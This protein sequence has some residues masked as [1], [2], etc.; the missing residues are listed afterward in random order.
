[1]KDMKSTVDVAKSLEA[2]AYSATANGT[3]VDLQGYEGALFVY[4]M[5]VF[6]G[7]S[8][9]A[10]LKLQES[11]DNVTFTDVAAAD[12]EGTQPAAITGAADQIIARVGYK[13]SKRY[14]RAAI[15]AIGG[16]SPSLPLSASVV[17]GAARHNPLT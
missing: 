16:T 14:L 11:D 13:G 8:P 5:G 3:G 4:D 15:T 9:T 6:G 10:T 1:M 7:T 2:A 12:L 17:R